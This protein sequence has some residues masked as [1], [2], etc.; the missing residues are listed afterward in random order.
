VVF[1]KPVEI[2][3][4]MEAAA[5]DTKEIN[6]NNN[7]LY[8]GVTSTSVFIGKDAVQLTNGGGDY[9]D[10][11]DCARKSSTSSTASSNNP[12]MMMDDDKPAETSENPFASPDGGFVY[13]EVVNPFSGMNKEDDIPAADADSFEGMMNEAFGS[14][15]VN[16]LDD[17]K[18][19]SP[20][21]FEQSMSPSM[22]EKP[23]IAIVANNNSS[24]T[25][26]F[27]AT[28][29][30]SWINNSGPAATANN[31]FLM[32]KG[33]SGFISPACHSS[34]NQSASSED[35]AENHEERQVASSASVA[36]TEGEE[37]TLAKSPETASFIDEEAEEAKE[38]TKLLAGGIMETQFGDL[39][40]SASRETPTPPID[41]T[42]NS[43]GN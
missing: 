27:M 6:T 29:E 38:V 12:F 11:D 15:S 24:N 39:M 4:T 41:E 34:N 35:S 30:H 8:D 23:A 13:G 42:G 14:V 1:L 2:L 18:N 20:S 22:F 10:D 21:M 36:S 3:A 26:D 7:D 9:D 43:Y 37:D 16:K 33:D 40:M 19:A 31:P 17:F 5:T 25:N 28:T 32:G